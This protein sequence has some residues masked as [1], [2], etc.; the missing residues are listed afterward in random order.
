MKIFTTRSN[1]LVGRKGVPGGMVHLPEACESYQKLK[2]ATLW[3]SGLLISIIIACVVGGIFC[4]SIDPFEWFEEIKRPIPIENTIH[5]HRS[6]GW[7]NS[8]TGK[9]GIYGIPDLNSEK[10]AKVLFWGDSYVQAKQVNDSEKLAQSFTSIWNLNNKQKLLGVGIGFDG[11]NIADNYFMMPAYE[12]IAKNVFCHVFII[13][14]FRKLS[15]DSRPSKIGAVFRSEP[16]FSLHYYPPAQKTKSYEKI[17]FISSRLGVGFIFPLLKELRDY[18]WR[19]SLG[20]YHTAPRAFD[21]EKKETIT[22]SELVGDWNF[23]LDKLSQQ[24][25][26]KIIFVYLPQVPALKNGNITFHDAD[27][28]LA[29][30]FATLC[31]G[32]G[33][34]YI[35][36][37]DRFCSYFR[38]T[39]TFPRG[40]CNS[41]PY[42]GHLNRDGHRM[43]AEEIVKYLYTS[44]YVIHSN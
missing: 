28:Q 22:S 3:F 18:D 27:S 11:I 26:K 13:H 17:V 24:T 15:S 39:Y 10:R 34:S 33:M 7:A 41:N 6:E 43:V 4:D 5:R 8:T 32:H 14:D 36:M 12:K 38:E 20:E 42:A 31:K 30:T 29:S 37:G 19:F 25:E 40:F 2:L 9:F 44:N 21:F 1:D 35:N 23:L 16:S